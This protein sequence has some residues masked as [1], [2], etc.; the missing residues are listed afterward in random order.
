MRFIEFILFNYI[1]SIVLVFWG[2]HSLKDTLKNTTRDMKNSSL[3]PFLSGI[4]FS[5]G[6]IFFGVFILIAKFLGKL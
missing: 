2:I 5:I 1:T 3:Q 4:I 6:L